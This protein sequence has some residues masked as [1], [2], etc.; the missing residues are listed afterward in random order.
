VIDP[1]SFYE[2]GF[3][4]AYAEETRASKSSEFKDDY[5][6][7]LRTVE[8]SM[9]QLKTLENR[10]APS[11]ESDFGLGYWLRCNE[12]CQSAV[13]LA[14]LGMSGAA[15][16]SQR[17][18]LECLFFAAAC[19]REPDK[20][21][22]EVPGMLNSSLRVI[23]NNMPAKLR[24]AFEAEHGPEVPALLEALGKLKPGG[25]ALYERM[26]KLAGM[27]DLYDALY[28]YLSAVGAHATPISAARHREL[29]AGKVELIYLPMRSETRSIWSGVRFILQ[30]GMKRFSSDL[31]PQLS[32][33]PNPE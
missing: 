8:A 19:W 27:S 29:S 33:R 3:L 28:R 4:S 14:D 30:Q 18:A 15:M 12:A 20:F 16:G 26:A 21:G 10:P 11:I 1:A 22:L 25:G 7:V 32:P 24:A 9:S 6:L 23:A 13:M 2:R 31:I 17:L 5:A